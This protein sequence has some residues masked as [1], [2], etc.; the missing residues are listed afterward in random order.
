MLESYTE[1]YTPWKTAC[2]WHLN[3]VLLCPVS[4]YCHIDDGCEAG[5]MALAVDNSISYDKIRYRYHFDADYDYT[6]VP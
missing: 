6:D 1:A 4:T 3:A 2:V 5:K